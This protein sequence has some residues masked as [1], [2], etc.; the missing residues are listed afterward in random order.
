[1]C[2]IEAVFGEKVTSSLIKLQ[3][4]VFAEEEAEAENRMYAMHAVSVIP[5]NPTSHSPNQS[6]R[7]CTKFRQ[8][9]ACERHAYHSRSSERNAATS[10]SDRH[11][12]ARP[13]QLCLICSSFHPAS[14]CPKHRPICY[15]ASLSMLVEDWRSPSQPGDRIRYLAPEP[16][17]Q[18]EEEC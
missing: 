11:L 5:R 13:L 4:W 3:F 8:V 14:A 1:M 18:P 10:A 17:E 12:T 6:D 16:P 9:S 15:L 7:V 2:E